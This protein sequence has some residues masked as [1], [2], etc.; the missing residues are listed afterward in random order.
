MKAF[1]VEFE[2]VLGVGLAW[3]GLGHEFWV[4]FDLAK[5]LLPNT[6][7]RELD[8]QQTARRTYGRDLLINVQQMTRTTKQRDKEGEKRT[9]FCMR[10]DGKKK[11]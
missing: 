1:S 4:W 8:K 5:S 9:K 6:A 7:H 11:T 10:Q 2:S 3:V